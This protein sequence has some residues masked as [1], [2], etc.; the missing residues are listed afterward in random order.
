MCPRA[1][2]A[3]DGARTVAGQCQTGTCRHRWGLYEAQGCQTG[4]GTES[5]DP[6][7]GDFTGNLPWD[8]AR[9]SLRREE[10]EGREEAPAQGEGLELLPCFPASPV[11]GRGRLAVVPGRQFSAEL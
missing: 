10:R 2:A 9:Y 5:R 1:L 8:G 4:P 11:Q 7:R 3:M 6:G